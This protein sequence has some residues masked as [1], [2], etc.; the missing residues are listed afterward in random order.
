MAFRAF[1]RCGFV[2]KNLSAG[3]HAQRLVTKITFHIGVPALQRELSPLIVIKRGGHP[4]R[5]VVAVGAR[6]LSGLREELTAVFIRV[7]FLAVLRC[8]LELRLFRA[9]H[10][11]VA[12]TTRDRPMCSKQRKLRLAVVEAVH[13]GPR[14]GVVTSFAAKGRAVWPMP[15][16]S[17]LKLPV[18]RVR[19]ASGAAAVLEAER[20]NLIGAMRHLRLVAIVAGNG[21]VSAS[22]RISRLSMLCDG[23]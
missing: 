1:L 8:A 16:H 21:R 17:V 7:A 23:E 4:S 20:Q 14:P 11:F 6:R 3:N 15:S 5:D 12:R 9:R 13:I 22:Q 10:R 2:K 18:M 19:M